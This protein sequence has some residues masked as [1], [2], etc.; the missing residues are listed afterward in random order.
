MCLM[1]QVFG[2]NSHGRAYQDEWI[3]SYLRECW[4]NKC[5][6]ES[7]IEWKIKCLNNT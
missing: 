2:L 4:Y 3:D 5:E 6:L 1:L 7:H